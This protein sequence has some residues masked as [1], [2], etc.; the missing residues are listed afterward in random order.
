M[1]R[2]TWML[3]AV[4]LSLALLPARAQES[5]G[6]FR[7]VLDKLAAIEAAQ[8]TLIRQLES[9]QREFA[10]LRRAGPPPGPSA[11][12]PPTPQVPGAPVVVAGA[13]R[14][15]SD[16]AGVVIV[17]YAD[18]QCPFCGEFARRTLPEIE[19]KYV[20][21]GLVQ[22]VFKH[23]P[24]QEI[25]PQASMAAETAECASQQGKFWEV[26]DLLFADQR[27]DGSSLVAKVRSAQLDI[28]RFSECVR[29]P[30][31]EK[32]RA[33]L[34]GARAAGISVT[35]TFYIG[36]RQADGTVKVERVLTGA[37]DFNAFAA[38]LDSMLSTAAAP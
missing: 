5:G 17:E 28:E 31:A 34:A 18:F 22:V 15:G 16:D 9:M 2:R 7:L 11:R 4:A 29:G 10:E 19:R 23:L 24:L 3:L 14:K 12:V 38:T 32:V 1:L 13:P 26:H 6:D 25:H 21:P 30:G 37:R 27:L 36:R 8:A 33:D 35:P 20:A